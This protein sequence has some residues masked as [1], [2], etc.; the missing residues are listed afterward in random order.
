MTTEHWRLNTGYC[1]GPAAA[2]PSLSSPIKQS[3]NQTIG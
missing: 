3:N 1:G 2:H